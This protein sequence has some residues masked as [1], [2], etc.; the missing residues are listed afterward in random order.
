MTRM[1]PAFLKAIGVGMTTALVGSLG[2]VALDA[3]DGWFVLVA[4]ASGFVASLVDPMGFYG[5][6]HPF[7]RRSH[8]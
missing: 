5:E 6:P 1:R 2:L 8:R 4:L 3:G 7:A